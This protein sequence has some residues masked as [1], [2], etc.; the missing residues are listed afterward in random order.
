[1][2][3]FIRSIIS[4]FSK[5]WDRWRIPCITILIAFTGLIQG[6]NAANPSASLSVSKSRPKRGETITLSGNYRD[7]DGNLKAATIRNLGSGNKSGSMSG[8]PSI[9]A[10]GE[11]L[12]GSRDSISRRFTIPRGAKLGTY[13]FRTEVVDKTSGSA[14]RWRTVSVQNNKPT[15]SISVSK[16]TITE[17]GSVTATASARDSDGS[18]KQVSFFRDGLLHKTDKSAPYNY[19][20]RPAGVGKHRFQASA[21]D[22]EGQSRN[23]N[24]V[25]VNVNPK[26]NAN[27]VAALS[28]PSNPMR[29]ET[30]SLIGSYTDID[31]N[32]SAATIRDLGAGQNSG[33]RGTFPSIGSAGESISGGSDSIQRNFTIPVEIPLGIYTFRTEVVDTKS[34]SDIKWKSTNVINNKPSVSLS[35]SKTTIT[36][37]D[38]VTARATASDIDGTI[39]RVSFF[40][41]NF[42]HAVDTTA[43]FN[44]T[45]TPQGTGSR[46][47]QA[48]A[49]DNDEGSSTSSIVTLTVNPRPN[50][51]PVASL[52]VDNL[53]PEAGEQIT[54]TGNYTDSDGNLQ[55]ATIRDLGSGDLS[56]DISDVPSIGAAGESVTGSSDS[57]QRNFTIPAGT[58]NGPY[59]FR[60]E[61]TDSEG[62]SDIVWTM[63]NVSTIPPVITLSIPS[64]AYEGSTV[65]VE[66]TATGSSWNIEDI[67]IYHN[68]NN[69][70]NYSNLPAQYSYTNAALGTHS[71]QATVINEFN[72]SI[73]SNTENL[74]V[75][76]APFVSISSSSPV[77]TLNN[78]VILDVDVS[79]GSVDRVK[80]YRG[81]S[82]V[83]SD[84]SFP[85]SFTDTPSTVGNYDYFA[86]VVFTDGSIV[87]SSSINIEVVDNENEI[88]SDFNN[89]GYLDLKL[90]VM[91]KPILL[92]TSGSLL[93]NDVELR[94][95]EVPLDV[96]DP[97]TGNIGIEIV[98]L[99]TVGFD[100]Q[101]GYTYR[102]QYQ[103]VLDPIS[104]W[105]DWSPA[106]PQAGSSENRILW[107]DYENLWVNWSNIPDFFRAIRLGGPSSVIGQPLS[108]DINGDGKDEIINEVTAGALSITGDL[109]DIIVS[110]PVS[111]TGHQYRL[112]ICVGDEEWT[113]V[114]GVGPVLGNGGTVSISTEIQSDILAIS[115]FRFV[116]FALALPKVEFHDP[117]KVN[118]KNIATVLPWPA[119]KSA[120][121][122][123]GPSQTVD[124]A[125]YLTPDSD[126]SNINWKV[127][128][129][130]VGSSVY[131]YGFEPLSDEINEFNI[132]AVH[133]ND[134]NI[135]D[136]MILVII[137][138][139]TPTK[140][141]NWVNDNVDISWINDLPAVYSKLAAI[142]SD[143]EPDITICN[144]QRWEDVD[145]LDKKYH[146]FASYEMRSE[147]INGHG[148]QACY[149]LNG[150]LINNGLSAGTADFA[151]HSIPLG[152]NGHVTHD[153]LPFIWAAQLDGNPVQGEPG[154]TFAPSDLSHPIMYEGHQG[155]NLDTYLTLRPI[156]A[157]NP[158]IEG[159]CVSVP[160]D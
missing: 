88:W 2:N 83:R 54:I 106:L 99:T 87:E 17:G 133:L 95:D 49:F 59:I 25:Y 92:G 33:N 154:S 77:T 156:Y 120:S 79:K 74:T 10:A 85:Y 22:N 69:V 89:D 51:P 62:A 5:H 27:P 101:Q 42:L 72:K 96:F 73:S 126:E 24:V 43:P 3:C 56:G 131:N 31:G 8:F 39:N 144:P 1:M 104:P 114:I 30:I 7:S 112:Q 157:D 135:F 142:N 23:S 80:L 34:G 48:S 105:I 100:I 20:Y 19:T 82:L 132:E 140:Y 143:P 128:D 84:T 109:V 46:K 21:V 146:P 45:Y 26:P 152:E 119:A 115:K 153:V 11:R 86:Q 113:D 158:V 67:I 116:E 160:I 78:A 70:G 123:W 117:E 147:V 97:N 93:I 52:S 64:T 151:H 44:Y 103:D 134:D 29:G 68:G 13:T 6:L 47:F 15:V 111:I 155:S 14:I 121:L 150:D 28:A 66:I 18:I 75:T 138:R 36:E 98:P 136:R 50:L 130:V 139:S 60:T 35:L 118:K 4:T 16:T 38:S 145:P 110:L 137:P 127:N 9:G 122:I 76:A 81:G 90:A 107:C 63:V 71:F 125:Y 94:I 53:T 58:P 159:E 57:I 148:H 108:A 102:V 32:L 149:N 124:L 55:A 61:V 129:N 40:R 65:P 41:D 12:S 37:G 141:N 91:E